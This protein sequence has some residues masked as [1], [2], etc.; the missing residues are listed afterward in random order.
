MCFLSIWVQSSVV[1]LFKTS[2]IFI[3]SLFTIWGQCLQSGGDRAWWKAAWLYMWIELWNNEH[4]DYANTDK[5]PLIVLSYFIWTHQTGAHPDPGS[6]WTEEGFAGSFAQHQEQ[7]FAWCDQS[8][9]LI[10][11]F[12][13]T[14]TEN[15][16]PIQPVR[17]ECVRDFHLLM[18]AWKKSTW[19]YMLRFKAGLKFY[20]LFGG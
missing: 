5:G 8:G 14:L 9:L 18:E 1:L 12:S 10:M 2:G 19:L 4:L 11:P 20:P 6:E 7:D 16:K 17:S 15:N 3:P 13:S